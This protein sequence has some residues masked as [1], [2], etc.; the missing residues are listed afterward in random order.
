[1]TGIIPLYSP[2]ITVL[3]D[4]SQANLNHIKTSESGL[5]QSEIDALLNGRLEK[6]NQYGHFE[7][8]Y[9]PS[10]RDTYFALYVLD[11]IEKLN[12][13]DEGVFY[14]Y[15]IDHYSVIT[16]EFQDDFS[17]RFY[18]IDNSEAFYQNSPLLTYC[19]AVLSLKILDQLNSL[20]Q[21]NIINYIWSC[22]DSNTGGFFGMPS[23][24]RSPQNISTA[25]NT[26]FAVETLNELNID[27]SYYATQKTQIISFLNSLQIQSP[28]NPFTHGG[29]NNDLDDNVDTVLRYDPNLRSAYFAINTLDSL[30]MLGA[31]NL[32]NFLQYMG[33]LYDLNSGCFFYNYFFRTGSQIS[34]NIISTA[35]GMELADLIG[36]NYDNLLSLNFLLNIRMNGGGWENTQYLGNYELIDTY[37]VIRY[38]KRND[39]LSNLDSLVKEEIYQFILRFHH[40]NGFSSFSRDHTSLKIISNTVKAFKTHNRITDLNSYVQELYNIIESVHKIYTFGNL[41][42]GTFYGPVTTNVSSVNYRTAPLEYKG[43]KNHDYSQDIGFLHSVEQIYYALSALDNIFKLDDFSSANNL[44]ELLEHLVDCQFLESGYERYG[45]FLP[46]YQFTQYPPE[47]Y[48]DFILLHYTYYAIRCIEILDSEIDDGD[49]LDNGI[50]ILALDSFISRQLKVIDQNIYY[51]PYYSDEI[52]DIIENT[53]FMVYVLKAFDIYT[54]ET[55]KIINYIINNID[56]TNLRDVYYLFKLSQLLDYPVDLD[57]NAVRI[58]IRDLY[59]ESEKEFLESYNSEIPNTDVL[60]WICDIVVNDEIRLNYNIENFVGLGYYFSINASIC[61]LILDN[62]EFNSDVKFESEDLGIFELEQQGGVYS[63]DIYV[64]LNPKFI[65]GINGCLSA[66]L[67]SEKVVEASIFLDTYI[68]IVSEKSYHNTSSSVLKVQFNY[69]IETSL[70]SALLENSSM[71]VDVILNNSFKEKESSQNN[72]KDD[73]VFH[74]FLYNF[75]EG[76]EYVLEFYITH[77]YLDPFE[78]SPSIGK[79]ELTLKINVSPDDFVIEELNDNDDT[80]QSDTPDDSSDFNPIMSNIPIISSIFGFATILTVS[81]TLIRRKHKKNQII[82]KKKKAGKKDIKKQEDKL[83]LTL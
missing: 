41:G 10:I 11:A 66:Y 8:Y 47:Y 76:G 49:I 78:F 58:L 19:Y 23:P 74:E 56:Y 29:F 51:D 9:A 17:L 35:L 12:Q 37:E 16:N 67:G 53:Y 20:V 27:W 59:L 79:K 52:G 5:N 38:F 15:I 31:I 68:N 55:D 62:F 48:Q 70:G 65:S 33:G 40:L 45:G 63:R 34:Y 7:E 2:K 82:D 77:P 3:V 36:F 61:N 4:I 18:D 32:A 21:A 44:S 73:M 25:E 1:M 54:L 30:D 69:T 39:K 71:Y 24:D 60:Y 22:Y 64:P 42:E 43:T 75:S 57:L 50:D 81:S 14:N 46:D 13:T 83:D 80:D 6:Y 28:F 72:I 26:Y